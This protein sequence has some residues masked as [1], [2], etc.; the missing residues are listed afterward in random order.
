MHRTLARTDNFMKPNFDLAFLYRLTDRARTSGQN[1]RH[2]YPLDIHIFGA[3]TLQNEENKTPFPKLF[4]ALEHERYVLGTDFG[5]NNR[6]ISFPTPSRA[7]R[8]RFTFSRSQKLLSYKRTALRSIERG[9]IHGCYTGC[10]P[11]MCTP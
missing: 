10:R 8:R 3:K 4:M 6:A 11:T 5:P 9:Y 2:S 1:L 7:T